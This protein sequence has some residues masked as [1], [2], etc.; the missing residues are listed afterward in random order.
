MHCYYSFLECV[1]RGAPGTPDIFEGAK[2]QRM[3]DAMVSSH[4]TGA[5]VD[6]NG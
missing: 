3:M 4:K 2:L 6:F 1:H 5:W